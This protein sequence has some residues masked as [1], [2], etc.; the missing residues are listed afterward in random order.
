MRGPNTGDTA[1]PRS[2]VLTE[3]KL[4]RGGRFVGVVLGATLQRENA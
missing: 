3:R 1:A 2:Q 4:Q